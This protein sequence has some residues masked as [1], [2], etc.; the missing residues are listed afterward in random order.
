MGLASDNRNNR[1]KNDKCK[2]T[3]DNCQLNK[4][5]MKIIF[6]I[7]FLLFFT[8]GFSQNLDTNY[9]CNTFWMQELLE[10]DSIS[11]QN[12]LQDYMCYMIIFDSLNKETFRPKIDFIKG[13][14][15]IY[16]YSDGAFTEML[17]VMIFDYFF[18]DVNNFFNTINHHFNDKD[19]EVWAIMISWEYLMRSPEEDPIVD[20]LIEEIK[21]KDI[22][23]QLES[24][25]RFEKTLKSGWK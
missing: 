6:K 23:L 20:K 1:G 12:R 8:N 16:S 15:K 2:L 24:W 19:Y 11:S 4:W 13:I 14:S 17:C 7:L 21:R 5:K 25:K 22:N 9:H 10:T 18:S 3:N